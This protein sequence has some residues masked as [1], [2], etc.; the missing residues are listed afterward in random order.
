M[1]MR[2]AL[3]VMFAL[4]SGAASA[5]PSYTFFDV[6]GAQYTEPSAINASGTVAGNCAQTCGFVRAPDGTVTTFGIS[7]AISVLVRGINASGTVIGTYS[8]GPRLHGFERTADGAITAIDGNY[9]TV[10][11]GINDSGAITGSFY[12]P[13]YLYTAFL[14]LPDGSVRILPKPQWQTDA[15]AG[16]LNAFGVVTG[17]TAAPA[18]PYRAFVFTPKGKLQLFSAPKAG[19]FGTVGVK[20]DDAGNIAGYYVDTSNVAHGFLRDTDGTFHSFNVTRQRNCR[21]LVAAL[22]TVDGDGQVIGTLVN[23]K[24]HAHA[25]IHHASGGTETFDLSKA[26]EDTGTFALAANS[27][28]VIV[29]EFADHKHARGFIRTP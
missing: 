20:I 15:E 24:F 12:E 1:T 9:S 19:Q 8:D 18:K 26:G 16:G 25:F 4:V 27:S 21:P 22:V 14:R 13:S 5:D 10:L 29:G 17:T 23:P 3:S 11:E 7:G 6:P 2:L 28:G